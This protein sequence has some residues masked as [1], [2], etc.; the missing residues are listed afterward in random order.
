MIKSPCIKK[1][2]LDDDQIYIGC[3][4][5][6]NE[7]DNWGELSDSDINQTPKRRFDKRGDDYYGNPI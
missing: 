5:H 2:Q 7:I 1:C 4:R 3:F 6:I